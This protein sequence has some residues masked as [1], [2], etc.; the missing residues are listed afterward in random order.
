MYRYIFTGVATLVA[1][2][3]FTEVRPAGGKIIFRPDSDNNIRFC[4]RGGVELMKI[5]FLYK[6]AWNPSQ[7]DINWFVWV[8]TALA[9][10]KMCSI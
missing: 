6:T 7:F 2:V 9:I 1:F 3:L 5:P 4:P 10:V 8:T